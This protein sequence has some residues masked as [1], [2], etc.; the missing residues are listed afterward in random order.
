MLITFFFGICPLLCAH[1]RTFPPQDVDCR[2]LDDSM[3]HWS[4][5]HT[6]SVAYM[7]NTSG[8]LRVESL[9]EF[10]PGRTAVCHQERDFVVVGFPSVCPWHTFGQSCESVISL[11]SNFTMTKLLHLRK[12]SEKAKIYNSKLFTPAS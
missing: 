3:L 9:K 12:E 7:W 2:R 5:L 4:R 10:L 8:L 1:T 11:Q 6:E